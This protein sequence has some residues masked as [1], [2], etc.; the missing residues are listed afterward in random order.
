LQLALDAPSDPS[1]PTDR[2]RAGDPLQQL[3]AVLKP[4]LIVRASTGP[5]GR[6]AK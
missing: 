5:V 1:D 6:G 4:T 2:S 3:P